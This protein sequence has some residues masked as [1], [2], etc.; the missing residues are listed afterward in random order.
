MRRAIARG[1]RLLRA[2][3]LWTLLALTVA[4]LWKIVLTGRILAGVD[5]F[6][7]FYPYR[8]FLSQAIREGRFPLWNPYLFLG[9]PFFADSQAGALYPFNLILAWLPVPYQVSAAIAVHIALAGLFAYLLARRSLGLGRA[10]AFTASAVFALGGFL[11]AQAEH[12]NQLSISAY[13]PLMLYLWDRFRERSAGVGALRG[14]KAAFWPASALAGVVALCVLAGH[15]QSLYIC[16]VA[17]AVYAL[18]P[19]LAGW[20]TADRRGRRALVTR[21]GLALAALAVVAAF[22]L[23]LAAVQVL[24]TVELSRL[25]LRGGGMTYREAVSFSLRPR[26]LLTA[27][28]PQ[29]RA[30]VFSEYIAYV[31]IFG[32]ALALVGFWRSPDRGK[33]R[34]FGLMAGVGVLLALGGFNPLYYVLYRLVPGFDL[35]RVPAR[36][37]LLYHTGA[38]MLAGMGVQ[39][40]LHPHEGDRLALRWKPVVWTAA[41][42]VALV[43]VGAV[44]MERPGARVAVVWALCAALAAALVAAVRIRRWTRPVTAVLVIAVLCELFAASRSLAVNR[45]T[46]PQAYTSMRPSVAH[47]LADPDRGRMLSL[48]DL[49]FDPGD[50]AEIRAIYGLYLAGD[51]PYMDVLNQ[52]IYDYVVATKQKE[53]LVP[54]LPMVYGIASVDGYGGGILPLR[55][56]YELE[57]LFLPSD[58]LSRDGRLREGLTEIPDGRLLGAFGVK[59]IIADKAYDI[60]RDGV[61]YDLSHRAAFQPGQRAEGTLGLGADFPADALGVVSYLD[62]MA[63][64][65]DGTPVGEVLLEF[66]DG[67]Q[68]RLT[69]AAGR[70]TAEG[71][72]G[73]HVAHARA[74][75]VTGVRDDP[76]TACYLT[77]LPLDGTRRIRRLEITQTAPEGTL[78][79]RGASLINR[80]T[81]T[82]WPVVVSTAGRFELV[83]SGDVKIYRNLDAKPRLYVAF[84]A[85]PAASSQDAIDRLLNGEVDAQTAIAVEGGQA[86]DGE[87]TADITLLAD[88][89]ERVAA[90]VRL[91]APGYLVL[92]DT[93]YPGWRA[94]VD[95]EP[96]LI[97]RANGFVRAVFLPAGEHTVEFAFAPQSLI[98]GAACSGAALAVWLAAAIAVAAS[99][100][101]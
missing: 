19:A 52:A 31:G 40:L 54:N 101:A 41:G 81:G 59:Y 7:Y 79:I 88:E 34:V 72:Y 71:R 76:D 78:V 98:L 96:A 37:M 32:M 48:S 51:T 64:V 90:R 92:S 75:N 11:L 74:R 55:G 27:L 15:V 42:V 94:T 46:A 86:L 13:L 29:Y 44:W 23:V 21:A 26:L 84:R 16:L 82:H 49:I 89:A 12:V 4:F 56:Y 63:D 9:A 58:R 53:I 45:P 5:V 80:A 95:G 18:W 24:P 67:G 87:G 43:G 69:L 61:Y 25:S 33:A 3:P 77:V 35:F 8:A 60:W 20:A 10:G 93:H 73:P 17:A 57:R 38:A 62:G 100:R 28:L 22:G 66:A 65:P 50:L 85:V 14:I 91:D 39:A 1:K 47:L 2:W 70:D 97:L 36:W 30:G 6:T 99:R 83:H 68:Q